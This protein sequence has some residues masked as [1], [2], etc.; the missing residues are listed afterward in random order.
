MVVYIILLWEY[1]RQMEI[2]MTIFDY[3][4]SLFYPFRKVH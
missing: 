3:K 2:K 1:G 4:V